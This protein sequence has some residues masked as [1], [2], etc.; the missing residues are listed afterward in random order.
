VRVATAGRPD[1]AALFLA[2]ERGYFVRQGLDVETVQ[3]TIGAEMV[4][5]LATN[6]IQV[7][8]GSPSAALFNALNRGVNIR[9]VADFAHIG[10]GDDT[11]VSMLVRKELAD[12]GA[13]RTAADLKGRSVSVGSVRGTIGDLFLQRALATAGAT[14]DD[15]QLVDMS[16][17]DML[18]ALA[19]Q[20]LDAGLLTEPQVTQATEQGIARVLYPGG[21]V[22]PNAVVSV[23]QYSPQFAADQ[24]DVATRFMVAFLQGVR[25]YHDAF[26]LKQNRDAAIDQLTQVLPLKDRHIW[27]TA[28]PGHTDLNGRV[29]VADLRDQAAFYAQ[30]GTLTGTV[31]DV[32]R[33]VDSQFAEAAVRQLGPR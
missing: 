8:N 28:A 14:I 19:N 2:I 5:A 7:G 23:L 18:G 24:P 22:I 4:P 33:F 3:F 6:Q 15:V 21:R 9:M 26:H 27:E 17:P 30:Q 1:Q 31:P 11:A 12:S 25:D 20:N 10:P 13:V 29:N 16:F 32:E